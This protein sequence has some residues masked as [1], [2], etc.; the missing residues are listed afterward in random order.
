ML[1]LGL[2]REQDGWVRAEALA[3]YVINGNEAV[4]AGTVCLEKKNLEMKQEKS[5]EK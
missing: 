1:S 2:K 5:H 4:I 3:L